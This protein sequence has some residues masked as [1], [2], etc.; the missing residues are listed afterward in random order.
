[1]HLVNLI[2]KQNIVMNLDVRTREEAIKSLSVKLHDN[3]FIS[4]TDRFYQDVLQRESYTTTGIGN[5]IAIPHG[6]SKFVNET[7][8]IF[9]NTEHEI[10]WNSLDGSKVKIIFLMAVAPE[11]QGNDHLQVLAKIASKLMD[12]D[13]VKAI[14]QA[15]TPDQVVKALSK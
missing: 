8:V 9:A 11:N 6:K 15:K 2:D 12:D 3:G 5:G 1:M 4:D 7:T 14:K 10:E 13:F